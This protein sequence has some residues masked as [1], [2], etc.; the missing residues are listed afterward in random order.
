MCHVLGRRRVLDIN[1]RDYKITK[2]FAKEL[3]EIKERG[4]F[5]ATDTPK[6]LHL[7]FGTL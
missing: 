5:I 1:Q 3:E 7:K 4:S 6:Y 2:R